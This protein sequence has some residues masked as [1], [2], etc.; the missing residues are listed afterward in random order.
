MYCKSDNVIIKLAMENELLFEIGIN[1]IPDF[2]GENPFVGEFIGDCKRAHEN[3]LYDISEKILIAC[4]KHKLKAAAR[5]IAFDKKFVNLYDFYNFLY[6][7]FSGVKDEFQVSAEIF[8]LIQN[9]K[10]T[11]LSYISRVKELGIIYF[12]IQSRKFGNNLTF[13]LKQNIEFEITKC[14]IRGLNPLI[15][16]GVQ[17]TDNF[18]DACKQAIEEEKSLRKKNNRLIN[19]NG[20]LVTE[21]SNLNPANNF[22][23][24][25]CKLFGHSNDQC[26]LKQKSQILIGQFC[27]E[28]NLTESCA[29]DNI[30]DFT[31]HE[32]ICL[33]CKEMRHDKE[34]CAKFK[35]MQKYAEISYSY[36][37]RNEENIES[38]INNIKK[39]E[40]NIIERVNGKN[41][42]ENEFEVFNESELKNESVLLE[43]P[44]IINYTK[45]ENHE[46]IEQVMKKEKTNDCR[47]IGQ[48]LVKEVNGVQTFNIN[49]NNNI[50]VRPSVATNICGNNCVNDDTS[51]RP[52]VATS[53][54]LNNFSDGVRPCVASKFSENSALQFINE[55]FDEKYP[56][57]K[58]VQFIKNSLILLVHLIYK[59]ILKV[60]S[61]F[62]QR[63]KNNYFMKDNYV[64]NS[65]VNSVL[66]LRDINYIHFT[67]II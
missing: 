42:T 4:F 63:F 61:C 44:L 49:E 30:N 9:D 8:N 39:N 34:N 6:D 27:G 14:F 26:T 11:I 48:I 33:Y 50:G 43:K 41:E 16:L 28:D 32:E 47:D 55:D 29:I 12:D 64:L 3:F 17:L 40:V 45:N 13:S 19:Y 53:V 21:E 58:D 10:E 25:S 31:Y 35:L 18:E 62:M 67:L 54:V 1:S 66:D 23:C 15:R 60:M 7:F 36:Y 65:Q 24:Q 59:I 22:Y 46:I 2:D 52:F 20:N 37:N 51:V 57:I 56:K 38:N 5:V